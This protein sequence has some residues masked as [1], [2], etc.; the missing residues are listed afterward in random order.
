MANVQY[1]FL[2]FLLCLVSTFLLKSFLGKPTKS[3]LSLPPSPLAL[4][5]IGHLHL[6][7]SYLPVSL[8]NLSTQYDPL[9]YLRLGASQRI[10]VSSVS[11]ATEIFKTQDLTFS[12]HP[13][14]GF[15]DEMP[16]AKY[17][18]FSA[19]YDDYW[20]FVKKLCMTEL[21]SSRQFERSRGVREEELIWFLRSVLEC[22]EKKEAIDVGAELMK[23]SN[24][25]LCRMAM[26]TRCSEKGDEA[27]GIRELVKDI[28]DVGS[29]MYLGDVL[30]PLRKLASWLYRKKA[31]DVFVRFDRLLERMLKDHEDEGKKGEHEDLMDILLKVDVEKVVSLVEDVVVMLTIIEIA[32][33]KSGVRSAVEKVTMPHHVKIVILGLSMLLTWSRPSPLVLLMMDKILIGI[34]TVALL[35]I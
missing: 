1:Y 25:T 35:L 29:K 32:T 14:L 18:F 27:E 13:E 9:F 16:Y 4:P 15:T 19:P 7:A 2:C 24:N 33:T 30:G 5:L 6:L 12:N 8:H 3:H 10:V 20:R 26:S 28:F 11:V 21:L 34:R 23:F 31:I 17:G 22:V